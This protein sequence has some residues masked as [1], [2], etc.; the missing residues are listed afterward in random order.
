MLIA[1]SSPPT[2]CTSPTPAERSSGTLTILSA[3]SVSSRIDRL[4]ASAI[5][6][7]GELSLSCLRMSGGSIVGGSRRSTEPTRSRTSCAAVSMSRFRWNV[8]L[9]I[10]WP[11]ADTD[12]SSLM[13]STR[14]TASSRTSE[15]CPSTSSTE[16]P[17]NVVRTMT[18]GRS[19]AGK[20]ST[21]RRKKA[22]APTTTSA[23]III[24]ARTGRRM[25]IAARPRMAPTPR[26]ESPRRR[27]VRPG[28]R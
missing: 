27:R 19:M 14:L 9:S 6:R 26:R 4:P 1:R 20:R 24:V 21:P 16:P 5:E 22:A 15:I 8:M 18:F 17:G 3:I 12:R 25:Q 28:S 7:T 11:G 23:M 13:P 2:I 10:D